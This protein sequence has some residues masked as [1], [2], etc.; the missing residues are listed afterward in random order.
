[1][2]SGREKVLHRNLLILIKSKNEVFDSGGTENIGLE[3]SS[4]GSEVSSD[5]EAKDETVVCDVTYEEDED[6]LD[7]VVTTKQIGDAQNPCIE[8]K[9]ADLD[10][11]IEE[12]Q[13]EEHE[14][15]LRDL[16]EI[17]SAERTEETIDEPEERTDEA[18]EKAAD[19]TG[20]GAEILQGNSIEAAEEPLGHDTEKDIQ[21][22]DTDQDVRIEERTQRSHSV[23]TETTREPPVPVPRRSTRDRHPP[24]R[25]KDI[26][27]NCMV[28]TSHDCKIEALSVLFNAGILD[29]IDTNIAHQIIG[30]VMK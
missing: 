24:N 9:E 26:Y 29:Q 1:M 15:S 2:G 8:V 7:F 28:E 17:V 4:N 3:K 5:K 16:E 21:H 18:G 20:Q 23:A 22:T 11:H 6:G 27:L 19:M 12:S 30:A 10:I 13:E 25:L 14:D